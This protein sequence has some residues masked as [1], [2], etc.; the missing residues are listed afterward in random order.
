MRR[1]T[2]RFTVT[3]GS[4]CTDGDVSLVDGSDANE[5][6]AQYCYEGYWYPLCGMTSLTASLMCKAMGFN[7]TGQ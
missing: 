4:E 2:C 6:R 7:S 3:T 5:G 1:Y